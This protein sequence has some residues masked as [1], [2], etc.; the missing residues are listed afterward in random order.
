MG[1]SKGRLATMTGGKPYLF[2]DLPLLQATSDWQRGGDAKQNLRRDQ[3]LK[4]A[5]ASLPEQDRTSPLASFRQVG[6]EKGSAWDLIRL[7][8]VS[9][10]AP[11]RQI[12]RDL[13]GASSMP[14]HHRRFSLPFR[15]TDSYSPLGLA[16]TSKNFPSHS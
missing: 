16:V 10:G 13:F 11:F 12:G 9:V 3:A 7:S 14:N 5:C 6:L 15:R 8:S 1:R 2:D 4:S